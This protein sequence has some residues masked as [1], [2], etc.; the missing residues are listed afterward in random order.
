MGRRQLVRCPSVTTTTSNESAALP[1]HGV[2]RLPCPRRPPSH[3]PAFAGNN[4]IDEGLL[5]LL[6]QNIEGARE[7]G[8][9]EAA[10]FMQKILTA[11][12]RYRV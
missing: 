6:Q 9:P 5:T 7:A 3:P 8:Q 11:A 4:E 1:Q 12:L 2:A 10:D